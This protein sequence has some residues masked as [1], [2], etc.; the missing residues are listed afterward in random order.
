MNN[1]TKVLI[2]IVHDITWWDKT[3]IRS[4]INLFEMGFDSLM[5]VQLR[6]GI[7]DRFT[8]KIDMKDFYET[9]DTLNKISEH[10]KKFSTD[11]P[12][13]DEE[14][15]SEESKLDTSLD[16]EEKELFHM[17][18]FQQDVK[19][20]D[21][22][23][24]K[25]QLQLVE[26]IINKQLEI[27]QKGKIKDTFQLSS[28]ISTPSVFK[29]KTIP[30]IDFSPIKKSADSL[31]EIQQK[32]LNDFIKR[33][34]QKTKNSKEWIQSKRKNIADWINSLGFRFSLKE[35]IY[36][37]ISEKSYGAKFWDVDGNEYVDIAMG[38]GS[39]FLGHN[40]DFVKKAIEEQ[41]DK[42]FEL[43]PQLKLSGEVASLICELTG[44]ERVA[45]C[46]S[47]SEAVMFAI[48][49][50]RTVT[51]RDGIILFSNSYH[52]TTDGV[53]AINIHGDTYPSAPGIVNG[54]VENVKVLN[55]GSEEAL[56]YI[57]KN[58]SHIAGVLIEPVQSRNP[59][60]QPFEF[61]KEV[62]ELADNNGF[63]LIFDE[64]ITGFRSH[65]GGFQAISGIVADI[66]IYGKALGGGVPV[67]AVAGK[68]KYLDAIDGGFWQFG[69]A[70]VPEAGMTFFAGTYFKHPLALAAVKA[71]LLHIKK[72]GTFLQD[73]T[74]QLMHLLAGRI[75]NFFYKNSVPVTLNYFSSMFRFEGYGKYSLQLNPIEMDLMFF[76]M[77]YRGIY[78]WEKRICFI[79]ASHTYKE[80]ELIENAVKETICEMR[81][82]GF[83]FKVDNLKKP[84]CY[85]TSSITESEMTSA[86]KRL[87][88]LG[89]IEGNGL[90]YNLPS[91]FILQ[92]EVDTSRLSWCFEQIIERHPVLKTN[93]FFENGKFIQK[94]KNNHKFNL[95]YK[96]IVNG[97]M[98]QIIDD[99]VKPFNL[100]EDFLFRAKLVKINENRFLLLTDF[101]HIV[102][103]GL[104]LNI[105]AR[106]FMDLY[107]GKLPGGSVEDFGKYANKEKEYT[108]SE[109]YLSD[110]K[111]WLDRLNNKVE[112]LHLPF[113]FPRPK[114]QDYRG[115]NLYF[116]I[117][118]KTAETLKD[119]CRKKRISLFT[120]FFTGF[121]ILLKKLTAQE[122]I[123]VGIPVDSRTEEFRNTIGMFANTLVFLAEVSNDV[124]V[125]EL[126]E[127]TQKQFLSDFE[128]SRYPFE[129]LINDMKVE[130]D[131]SRNP[132]FDVMYIF[133]NGEDRV[134]KLKNIVFEEYRY[135]RKTAMFDLMLETIDTK[136]GIN[137]RFEYSTALFKEETI[138]R[139]KEYYINILAEIL[140]DDSVNLSDLSYMSAEEFIQI[141]EEFNKSEYEYNVDE[142]IVSRL[143]EV[144]GR[145]GSKA[146]IICEDR[147]LSFEELDR[148][149]DEIS[150]KLL[151]AGVS[152]EERVILL[153]GRDERAVIGMFGILK[154][155]CAY[156]PI[157]PKFPTDRS[158]YIYET[159]GSSIILTTKEYEDKARE[160][161][162]SSEI[163]YIDMEEL[164]LSSDV[165]KVDI[166]IET[167]NLAYVMFTSG[168]TGK[169][170]GVMIEHRNVISFYH[171]LGEIWG[172]KEED[173]MLSVTTFTFDISVL[174]IICSILH[175]MSVVIST[176]EEN[177]DPEKLYER[178][179]QER[180][181]V[182]QSTPSRLGMILEVCG[183]K[184][185]DLFEKLLVGGEGLPF[186]MYE[187]LREKEGLESYNV[188]GPTETTIWSTSLSIRG[189]RELTI[190]KPLLNEQVYILGENMEVL[191]IGVTGEL[192][193]GGRGLGR[194]YILRE[195]LTRDRYVDSPFIEG[196]LLYK[197]GDYG[198]Y[199][200][201]GE[202]IFLGR[203]DEQVKIRGFRIELTEIESVV[204]R[205]EKIQ[206]GVV[207][208][209]E[210][211][212]VLYYKKALDFDIEE[213]KEH[214]RRWLPDY[215]LP[216]YYMEVEDFPL[217]AS[218]KV[219]RKRLIE[220][221]GI[222]SLSVVE[223][224][225][226]MNA[227]ERE[228][229][230]VFKEVLGKN[231]F[232]INS[233]FFQIGGDSIKGI[234][235]AN[236]LK[237]I[238]FNV[239]VKDIFESNTIK[240]L[241]GKLNKKENTIL[242]SDEKSSSK[243]TFSELNEADLDN[244][245]E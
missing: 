243:F 170:K 73:K 213:L 146:S 230:E 173:K 219:D 167:D 60:L 104:S 64:T 112:I 238:G 37:I 232:S 234:I 128:H 166:D 216:L 139:F 158:R 79:S 150:M 245:F 42:G 15:N 68:S 201:D 70:S 143:R 62:K 185:L 77:M 162:A 142:T 93:F 161:S 191:P 120:L 25:A 3:D 48:R 87:Y 130:R 33:Y 76:G 6:Q 36:P 225:E 17:E 45:F 105:F 56:E 223:V 179:K 175:G 208:L 199:R 202:I 126:L 189:S 160:I 59:S 72:H 44:V 136:D 10:I 95:E 132:L 178:G 172:F 32:F 186:D 108:K 141:T 74:N 155:G 28:E 109:D 151:R 184:F 102:A 149:S 89:E 152:K 148:Y 190:G 240:E 86:Q 18:C 23:L 123:S 98:E 55:Y 53:L 134:Y 29:R 210:G 24:F 163:F 39:V 222:E 187:K 140:M 181:N 193:I 111:Y 119:F 127:N 192:Y 154:S 137:C 100:S 244:I 195:D 197:T 180:C 113:D 7:I 1:I 129:N 204:S 63:A 110:K 165:S 14:S 13:M 207:C 159:S 194:G 51:K 99:F 71:S 88:M 196:E 85:I 8:I 198:K 135:N 215:M 118:S 5:L 117:P 19:V 138:K 52:G 46:N 65:P 122:Y 209:L 144:S 169:P 237:T 125:K 224:E 171:N 214:M 211:E 235:L 75:N 81:E 2:D 78:T 40:L 164:S 182:F 82:N 145:L 228:V 97:D 107:E 66:V 20:I 205:Y 38:Y 27:L 220:D 12:D 9:L 229:Y 168:S 92:G 124:S 236:R 57:K 212:L 26:R 242:H 231:N 217:N 176:E 203:R 84:V 83:E 218:G 121:I 30:K 156:V 41:L 221:V 188:Y 67:S 133:E 91:V 90:V 80:I 61:I 47:G 35:L 11:I 114:Y 206:K 174:E 106:E 50:A 16:I 49:L 103:D 115:A 101:H 131:L 69:D 43:G 233:N 227:R 96:E 153:C 31:N 183:D 177:Y 116:H 239:S 200:E 226:S 54:A 22:N 147:S 241:A 157:E 21:D 58:A 34:N 4:D 94:I